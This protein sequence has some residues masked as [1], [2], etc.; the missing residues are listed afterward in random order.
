MHPSCPRNVCD[1]FAVPSLPACKSVR[2]AELE[3]GG[4]GGED[5][6]GGG[7]EA[8]EWGGRREGRKEGE[9]KRETL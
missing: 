9:G 2:G 3:G 6:V 7:R 5:G 8:G 1:A 4:G